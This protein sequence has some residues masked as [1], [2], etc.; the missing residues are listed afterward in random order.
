ML[1][2]PVTFILR[3]RWSTIRT[4]IQLNHLSMEST[5]FKNRNKHMDFLL[6]DSTYLFVPIPFLVAYNPGN[7]LI[8][9]HKV[10]YNIPYII[11]YRIF[12]LFSCKNFVSKS[13][14]FAIA[15]HNDWISLIQRNLN[16]FVIIIFL[17]ILPKFMLTK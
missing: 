2:K 4:Y 17:G 7:F 5:Y 8:F 11:Q 13:G 1:F 6:W 3:T 12:D 15:K 16:N 10:H 9:D 14:I